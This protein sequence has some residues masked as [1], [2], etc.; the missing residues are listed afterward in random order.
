MIFPLVMQAQTV[1]TPQEELE[2]A[3]KQLEEAQKALKA[4]QQNAK[5]AAEAKAKVEQEA[6]AKAAQQ[7][8]KL[9]AMQEEAARL[10][11][12][13]D[14]INA[15]AAQLAGEEEQLKPVVVKEPVVPAT[16]IKATAGNENTQNS[17]QAESANG[18]AVPTMV[19]TEKKV[20]KK[21]TLANGIELKEDP[22][23]LEGAVTTDENGKVCFEMTTDANGKSAQQ[24]YNIVYQYMGQLTLGENNIASR[25]ALVNPSEHIIANAMDEWLVFSTSFISLDRTEFKYNLIATIK[26]NYLKLT[27]S[28]INYS[29]EADRSTGFKEPAEKVIID[30]VALNKKK[31]DLAKIFGKFRKGTIDRKDQIFNELSTLVKQ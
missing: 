23:Y 7:A 22:K 17:N 3:Q 11:A 16:T 1:L 27:L 4:A 20:E 9:K 6:Q 21:A 12:Q 25:V 5:K 8:A 19:A 2:Q 13:A 24:I 18:W 14:S 10:K 30:K 15:A 26:D 29:Y 31:N 28:R